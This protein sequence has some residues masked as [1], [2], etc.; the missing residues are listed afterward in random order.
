VVAS[1]EP[2]ADVDALV[3]KWEGRVTG[4]VDVPIGESAKQLGRTDSELRKL[5]ERAVA[6]ETHTDI[7]WI[8]AGG[9]RD[10]LPKGRVMAR[11]IWNMLPFDSRL[12]TGKFLGKELPKAITDRYPA[13]PDKEYTVGVP[14][15]V[16][17]NP[18][19]QLNNPDLRFPK[20]GPQ[21]RDVVI[22][23][24]RKKKT[25]DVTAAPVGTPLPAP[26]RASAGGSTRFW[27]AR[28]VVPDEKCRSKERW[29]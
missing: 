28:Q 8:N 1:L 5:L 6:E 3:K 19:G 24:I 11:D 4:I 26:V 14:D 29:C 25:V 20:K 21:L 2:A 12:M 13:E 7:V 16:A 23:W 18:A 27:W 17:Q 9:I 15:F 10:N 22:A